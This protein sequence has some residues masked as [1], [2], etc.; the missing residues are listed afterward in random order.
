M[1]DEQLEFI[2][3]YVGRTE[4]HDHMKRP[5]AP[6]CAEIFLASMKAQ[7]TMIQNTPWRCFLATG[8]SRSRFFEV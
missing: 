8:L 2:L 1:H 7:N 3:E 6:I 5:R 4:A